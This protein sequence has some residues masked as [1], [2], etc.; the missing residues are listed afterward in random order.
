MPPPLNKTLSDWMQLVMRHSIHSFIGFAKNRNYSI[1]QLNALIRL[2]HKGNCG[3]SDLGEETGVTNAAA[4]QLL[5][6]MV[7][8]GLVLRLEDP[9]DRRHKI[10]KLTEAGQQLACESLSARQSW[11][12]QLIDLL[13]PEEQEHVSVVLQLLIEKAALLEKT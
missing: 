12:T 9:Q 10:V 7:Q 11:L 6:K 13:T 1:A 5:E 3:I 4:S 2:Y 8:Q